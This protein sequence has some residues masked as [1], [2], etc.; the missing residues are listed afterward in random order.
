[1]RD[2]RAR[3]LEYSWVR[4]LMG[5]HVDFWTVTAEALDTAMALHALEDNDLRRRLL[6]AYRR[7]SPYPEVPGVLRQL[8]SK[9]LVVGVL[10]N[11]S[12]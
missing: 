4:S 2:W 11:G 12:P 10:S 9:G 5:R 6:D 7:L 1:S 3:Q 8:K